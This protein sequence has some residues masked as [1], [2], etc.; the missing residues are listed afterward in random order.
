MSPAAT[1][2][3]SRRRRAHLVDVAASILD[4]EGPAAVR[5]RRVA[6]LAGVPL[7]SVTYYFA[8]L[9]ELLGEATEH[10]LDEQLARTA[11]SVAALQPQARPEVEVAQLVVAVLAEDRDDA[12]MLAQYEL[13]LG[14]ARHPAIQAALAS[15][16]GEFAT[17]VETVL[18]RTGW[19]NA[20]VADHLMSL[21]D[22][23]IL[24]ALG[25]GDAGVRGRATAAVADVLRLARHRGPAA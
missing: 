8:T 25:E 5:H 22:G 18:E 3:R 10:L 4:E 1:Q 7:G 24:G 2:S 15:R 20:F 21:I 6:E 13:L 23:A 9:E 11:A 14:A 19:S 16:R 12:R 17:W